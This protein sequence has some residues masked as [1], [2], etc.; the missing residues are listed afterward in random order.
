MSDRVKKLEDDRGEL[1]AAAN[2]DS[3]WKACLD[4]VMVLKDVGTPGGQRAGACILSPWHQLV[5]YVYDC[6]FGSVQGRRDCIL[7]VAVTCVYVCESPV[8]L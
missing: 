3:A 8:S 1:V 7:V 4:G 2:D 5:L 6:G